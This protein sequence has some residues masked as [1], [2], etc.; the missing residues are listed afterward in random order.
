LKA[1]LEGKEKEI[2]S[3]KTQLGVYK[4][5]HKVEWNIKTLAKA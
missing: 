1:Q 2:E 4:Q 3:L 5:I